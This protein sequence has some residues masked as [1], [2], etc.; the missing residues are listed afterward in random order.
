MAQA[1]PAAQGSDTVT[2]NLYV[3]GFPVG[4]TEETVK[5]TFQQYGSVV[6]V[7]VLSSSG[8][9][10]DVACMVRM[11]EVE[12]AKWLIE[13][14]DGNILQGMSTPVNVKPARAVGSSGWGKGYG[15]GWGGYGGYGGVPAGY[16]WPM[17]NP[18]MAYMMMKGKGKGGKGKSLRDFPAEKKVWVGNL[19]ESVT[20]RDLH[21]HFEGVGQGR[22]AVVMKGKGA[23]TGG[24]AFQ[25]KEEADEAIAKYNGTML[26]GKEI[27]VDSWTKKES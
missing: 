17:M 13:H 16:G 25:T 26:A 27:Q 8:D 11:A 23:G 22:F 24:I 1:T 10:E 21:S 7:K 2:D 18:W 14:L 9:R 4:T 5:T 6:S 12:Q 19:D 15:K 3:T 20:F